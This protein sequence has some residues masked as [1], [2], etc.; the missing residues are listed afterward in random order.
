MPNVITE[1]LAKARAIFSILT[2]EISSKPESRAIDVTPSTT[3]AFTIDFMEGVTHTDAN[4]KFQGLG[5][6]VAWVSIE[7]VNEEAE[8]E[9]YL[10]GDRSYTKYPKGMKP[11]TP[12]II[13]DTNGHNTIKAIRITPDVANTNFIGNVGTSAVEM[14]GE[15]LKEDIEL[16]SVIPEYEGEGPLRK[17]LRK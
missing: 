7:A 13:K 17:R 2:A 9:Y 15:T 12:V 8:L 10:T 11:N 1:V 16:A 14:E 4:I 5:K 6:P 3:T